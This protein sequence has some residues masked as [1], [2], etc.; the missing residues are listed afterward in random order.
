MQCRDENNS[1]GDAQPPSLIGN[2]MTGR[3]GHPAVETGPRKRFHG[4]ETARS[5]PETEKTEAKP[6]PGSLEH[7]SAPREGG[8]GLFASAMRRFQRTRP[9]RFMRDMIRMKRAVAVHGHTCGSAHVCT[10]VVVNPCSHRA[11]I[12]HLYTVGGKHEDASSRQAM[13]IRLMQSGARRKS[14]PLAGR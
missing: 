9:P 13:C 7:A 6:P 2:R 4:E 5:P 1:G 10:H 8:V 12:N 11:R 14:V 3:Y